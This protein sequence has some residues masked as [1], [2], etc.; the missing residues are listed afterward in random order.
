M[1]LKAQATARDIDLAAVAYGLVKRNR[2]LKQ[3]EA[4]ERQE[5]ASS[6]HE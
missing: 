2:W 5:G 4:V 3:S 6:K 1:L